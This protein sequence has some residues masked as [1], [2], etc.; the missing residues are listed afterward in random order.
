MNKTTQYHLIEPEVLVGL[1]EETVFGNSNGD[2]LSIH[3][4]IEDWLGDDLLTCHP[5][6]LVTEQLK[7]KLEKTT[8]TGFGFASIKQSFDEYFNDN[9]QLKIPIPEFH[10]L[11][12]NGQESKD[13]FFINQDKN[14][15]VSETCFKFLKENAKL[16]YC[17]IDSLD[18]SDMDDLFD[19]L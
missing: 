19:D 3:M 14:L 15:M 4:N 18:D 9:F 12:I 10:W 11:K 6:F 7:S 1:G 8:L 5:V 2:L 17:E 13:D 16:E